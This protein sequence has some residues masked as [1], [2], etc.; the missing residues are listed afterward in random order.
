MIVHEMTNEECHEFLGQ[1]KFGRLGCARDGQPY[2][3]PIYFASDGKHLYCFSTP[4]QKI[5]WMRPNPLVCVE[6]DEVV[7]QLNWKSVVVLGKFEELCDDPS[8]VNTREYALNLLQ[9]RPTWWQPAYIAPEHR[10]AQKPLAPIYYRILINRITGHRGI[11][12]PI[13][14]AGLDAAAI[15]RPKA[16]WSLLSH[17]A[18]GRRNVC[19]TQ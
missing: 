16:R 7:D 4:G 12:D 3:V 9:K 19:R 6:V 13:E 8:R 17:L 14:K 11:P 1:M 10:D 18:L 5:E 15:V 2:I